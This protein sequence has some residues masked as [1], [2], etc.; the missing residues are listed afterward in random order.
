M[1]LMYMH[2]CIYTYT[3]RHTRTHQRHNTNMQ[4]VYDTNTSFNRPSFLVANFSDTNTFLFQACMQQSCQLFCAKTCWQWFGL[5]DKV[6]ASA[7]AT[8]RVT[9]LP[10]TQLIGKRY[11]S[12]LWTWPVAHNLCLACLHQFTNKRR[13]NFWLWS[14]CSPTRPIVGP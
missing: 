5:A 4:T 6:V 7:T 13:T 1:A 14:C 11:Y 8:D 12:N 9:N 10:C 3:S 2:I